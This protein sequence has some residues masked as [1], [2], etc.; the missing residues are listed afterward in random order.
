[1]VLHINGTGCL[2]CFARNVNLLSWEHRVGL[3]PNIVGP[4]YF[5]PK[6][7]TDFGGD[8]NLMRF[9]LCLYPEKKV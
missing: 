8:A 2:L 9:C 1:M 3:D 6:T 7:R 4:V 5:E